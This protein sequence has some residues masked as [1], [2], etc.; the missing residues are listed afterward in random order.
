MPV[1]V[2]DAPELRVAH[3]DSLFERP[4][5]DLRM[6]C[7][8]GWPSLDV[9]AHDLQT[10]DRFLGRPQ[11]A[12]VARVLID[13]SVVRWIDGVF[14]DEVPLRR[15]LPHLIGAFRGQQA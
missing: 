2:M 6:V 15:P 13:D 4:A 12:E 8:A 14:E 11:V 1:E 5:E 9:E 10:G 7:R 3:A